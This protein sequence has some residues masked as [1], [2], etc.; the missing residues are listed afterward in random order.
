M[1]PT[2]LAKI[3]KIAKKH[4]ATSIEADGVKI[5]FAEPAAGVPNSVAPHPIGGSTS[6][7]SAAG[8]APLPRAPSAAHEALA[9][10]VTNAFAD[11]EKSDPTP[12]DS[13]MLFLSTPYYDEL[14]EQE[15]AALKPEPLPA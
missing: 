1:K 15:K 10:E 4:G 13:K 9:L 6:S 2:E 11:L 12:S 8:P 3:I 14:V 7:Q 5:Y